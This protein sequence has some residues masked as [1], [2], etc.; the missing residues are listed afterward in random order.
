ME[1][2]PYH[3]GGDSQGCRLF[4]KWVHPGCER[5][6][7]DRFSRYGRIAAAPSFVPR[8]EACF[9]QYFDAGSAQTARDAED[10]KLLGGRA[11][12]ESPQLH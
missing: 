10:G 4:I 11:I 3:R 12:S 6:L 5:E 9:L 2:R 7:V 8:I 1:R